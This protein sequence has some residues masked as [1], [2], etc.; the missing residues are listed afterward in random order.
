MGVHCLRVEQP[1]AV[2]EVVGAALDFAY[3]A[4]QAVAVLLAQRLVGRK[5]W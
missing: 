5:V 4:E 1:E 2:P 3:G